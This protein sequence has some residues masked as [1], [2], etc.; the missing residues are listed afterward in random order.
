MKPPNITPPTKEDFSGEL[1]ACYARVFLG[2]PDG[3][4]I[5]ADLQRKFAHNRPRFKPGATTIDAAL[6]DGQCAVLK[7]IETACAMGNPVHQIPQVKPATNET[8]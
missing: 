8:H 3:K 2:T 1:A 5:L 7:E 6:I 4:R